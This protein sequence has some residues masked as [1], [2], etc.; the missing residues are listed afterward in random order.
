M[1]AFDFDARPVQITLFGRSDPGQ[2]RQENQDN[3]L[4]ADLSVPVADGGLLVHPD[5]PPAT[6]DGKGRFMIG[7]KGALLL[8][9]DGMGG[10]AAGR[11]AS[12]LAAE[13]IYRQ[14][15]AGWG[16]DRRN[17]PDQFAF[18]LREAVERANQVIHDESL[19]N[20]EYRGM[21]TTATVAGILDGFLYVAQVGDSRAYLVRAGVAT[22]LTRDQSYVQELVDAGQITEEEAEHSVHGNMILQALGTEPQVRVDLTYQ[23]IR[24]GDYLVICSDGLSRLVR[25]EEIADSVRRLVDPGAMCDELIA[26]A[27]VRGGPDN[28]TVLAARLDGPGLEEPGE[29]DTVGRRVYDIAAP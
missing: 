26:T 1:N 23:E 8:V 13:W 25:P 17:T 21:G 27:N 12:G 6:L 28:I 16:A 24:R 18:R 5:T 11:V 19:G 15:L 22:Q 4:I 7:P 29:A 14:L 2:K 9:A 10:A 3:F 20:P